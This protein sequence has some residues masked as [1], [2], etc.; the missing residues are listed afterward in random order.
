MKY[1]N[2]P[3]SSDTTIDLAAITNN[4]KGIIIAY[5]E[6]MAVGRVSYCSDTELW[7][8]CDNVDNEQFNTYE[9]TLLELINKLI[10]TKHIADNFRLLEFYTNDDD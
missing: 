8:F 4:Y 10:Y 6:D 9:G 3:K 7:C 5:K 2:I 1:I